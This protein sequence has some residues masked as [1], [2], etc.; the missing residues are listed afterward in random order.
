[1]VLAGGI[2]YPLGTC[3]SLLLK[4]NASFRVWVVHGNE[5]QYQTVQVTVEVYGESI[6]FNVPIGMRTNPK[7]TQ[8]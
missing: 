3:S 1:M 6:W 7:L 4:S 2:R 5:I 8:N